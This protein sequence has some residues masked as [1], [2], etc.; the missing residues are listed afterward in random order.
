MAGMQN[1]TS[2]STHTFDKDLNKDVNDFHLSPTSWVHARN[3]INN[4]KTGDLGKVGNEPA[5][6]L[7][8][9]APYTIIG[10]IH[11][12]ANKWAIFSTNGT[13]SEIG[14][15]FEET[16]QYFTVVNAACLNFKLEFLIK[17]AS[18]ATSDCFYEVYWDDGLNPSRYITIDVDDP[19]NNPST[20]PNSPIPWIQSCVVV[21]GCNICTNTPNLDCSKIRVARLINT[22]CV[23]VKKGTGG[24][25]LLNG[26]Y[27]V[28]IAYAIR[29]QKI[30]DWYVSNIQSLF[31]HDNSSSSLD[32]E[33]TSMDTRYDEVIVGV[34]SVINQQTVAR[35]AGIYSTHQ[36]R[37]SF[38]LI[39]NE[40][41]VIPIEQI[42]IM[43]PVEDKSDA[44]YNVGEYLIRVG[45]TSKFDF[46]YQPRA[47]QIEMRYIL[48][49]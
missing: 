4:S 34:V 43:T 29:G 5:N 39:S 23:E 37:L 42:P 15:F 8:T 9:S 1:T 25:V 35:Q 48:I 31:E 40:W 2:V 12:E 32:V 27:F 6:E 16:C 19:T 49:L 38:D 36:T 20:S 13:S 45:P 22:P 33:I 46:N 18:R 30:S 44:M 47:N 3:A 17:G 26:S 21:A 41:P 10:T 28:V 11:L 7:C 14:L 24:G